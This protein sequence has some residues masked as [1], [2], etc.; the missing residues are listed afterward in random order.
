V[1]ANVLIYERIKEELRNGNSPQAAIYAGFDRAFTTIFDS[2]ITNLLAAVMLFGIG[3][4]PV[5]GF[6]VTLTIGIIT[7]LFTAVTCTRM[8]VNWIYGEKRGVKL[9]IG[10]GSR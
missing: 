4:G 6:A 1:D 5:K 10:W 2:H 3:S 8:M 7:S 9:W